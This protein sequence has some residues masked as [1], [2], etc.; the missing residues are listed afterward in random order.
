MTVDDLGDDL[1]LSVEVAAAAAPPPRD[2]SFDSV[3]P[4]GE[5]SRDSSMTVVAV[6]DPDV[7]P[8][9]ASDLDL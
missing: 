8:A 6:D 9:G 4:A 3:P 1:E 5:S 7:A 2:L